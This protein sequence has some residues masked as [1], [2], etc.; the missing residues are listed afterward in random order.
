MK[1]NEIRKA[2][3]ETA[4]FIDSLRSAFGAEAV[5]Q[6]M[7]R[8][9]LGE[10]ERFVAFENGMRIGLE[11]LSTT[12][13][14]MHNKRGSMYCIEAD[15]IYAAR[16]IGRLK[17]IELPALRQPADGTERAWMAAHQANIRT[18]DLARSIYTSATD[19]EVFAARMTPRDDYQ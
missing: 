5:D 14:C 7:R 12:W 4:K 9:M 15:W 1:K 11:D 19:E 13:I 3:P 16:C 2:M 8:T 6:Q 18:A 10:S 17:G